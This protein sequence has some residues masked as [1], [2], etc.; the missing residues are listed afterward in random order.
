MRLS[1]CF[2]LVFFFRIYLTHNSSESE[3]IQRL[4]YEPIRLLSS[5]K[6]ERMATGPLQAPGAAGGLM[7]A[8]FDP[9]ESNSSLLSIAERSS[10]GKA[11]WQP[12]CRA[13]HPHANRA[14]WGHRHRPRSV[15]SAVASKMPA[16]RIEIQ[17][18]KLIRRGASGFVEAEIGAVV[19][20]ILSRRLLRFRLGRCGAAVSP[21]PEN[22]LA[23]M[24]P[25]T[26]PPATPIAVCAAPARNPPPP[27]PAIPGAICGGMPWMGCA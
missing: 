13:F 17:S 16:G 26:T 10:P 11:A 27:R 2:Y 9:G 1:I 4:T 20:E 5:A 19:A 23:I 24:L 14:D 22:A 6:L 18:A 7:A 15:A 3:S 8:A 21:P 25:R 12:L